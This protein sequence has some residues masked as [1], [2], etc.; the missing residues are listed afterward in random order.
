MQLHGEA[1]VGAPDIVER[2]VHLTA[3][4]PIQVGRRVRL[5]RMALAQA[6]LRRTQVGGVIQKNG[7]AI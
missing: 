4:R 3:K 1:A 6:R 2:R 7:D 5:H